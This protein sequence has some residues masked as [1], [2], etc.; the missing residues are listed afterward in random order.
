[1]TD[2]ALRENIDRVRGK[3]DL[4]AHRT[5]RCGEEIVLVAV[6]KGVPSDR[7]EEAIEA[8][9]A[10]FGENRIQEAR[11]KIERVRRPAAWHLVGHLQSNKA[12]AAATLFQMIHSLDSAAL[13]RR[14]DG[15]C[16]GRPD[17]LDVLVQVNVSGET[18]KSGLRP[19]NLRQAL[20]QI[21]LCPNLRVRGLMTI[22][23]PDPD[24]GKS[25]PHFAWLRL[26]AEEAHGWAIPGVRLD[27]LSMGM[28]D[29]FPVAIEEGA[30]MI[31]I[32]RAIFGE[33]I[34]SR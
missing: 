26:L 22:P 33:R 7:V 5:G 34:G 24:P 15:A 9:L 29:D 25:R 19:E 17:P 12:N 3:I 32:G 18:T 10:I 28:S 14:L 27:H 23:P 4:A 11:E 2:V 8:G 20:E 1:M 21:A 13:A 16:A 6:T 30:T 31:R